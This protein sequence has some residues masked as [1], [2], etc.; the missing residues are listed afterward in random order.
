MDY[1]QWYEK[2]G[3]SLEDRLKEWTNSI[4][5]ELEEIDVLGDVADFVKDSLHDTY[6]IY[7]EEN[8]FIDM[9]YETH[10]EQELLEGHC[11]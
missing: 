5:V 9:Q 6:L 3:A 7:T 8:E 11:F 4:P 2:Y 1:K 10:Q